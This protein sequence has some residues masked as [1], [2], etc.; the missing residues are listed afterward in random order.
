MTDVPDKLYSLEIRQYDLN[1]NYI[2]E[3]GNDFGDK[4]IGE[5]LNI[6]LTKSDGC[7]L[8]LVAR[9]NGSAIGAL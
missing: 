9:G 7:Q 1:G 3:T 4:N 6:T 5:R 2:P 8:M